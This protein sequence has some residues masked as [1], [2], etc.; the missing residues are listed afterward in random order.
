MPTASP[1]ATWVNEYTTQATQTLSST[2]IVADRFGFNATVVRLLNQEA[3]D[4]YVSF[5][6]TSV[7]TSGSMR[8][9]S[10]S[11][12]TLFNLAPTAGFSAWTTSTSASVK[13]LS[14]AAF[15]GSAG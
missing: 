4:F 10:C 5:K 14:I 3:V 6:S 15:G 1:G 11:E 8:V 7:A 12:F 13:T 9:R 2:S